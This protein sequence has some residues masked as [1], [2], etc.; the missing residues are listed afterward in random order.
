MLGEVCLRGYSAANL[1]HR[2]QAAQLFP[3]LWSEGAQ[4]VHGF[5]PLL[6]GHLL[7]QS[8]L[9]ECFAFCSYLKPSTCCTCPA[10]A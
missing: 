10:M 5:L 2:W 9:Q 1:L 6:H 3:L 8:I 7:T 4:E